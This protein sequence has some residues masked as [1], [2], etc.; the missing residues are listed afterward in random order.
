M[1]I[2]IRLIAVI[3]ITGHVISFL[4]GPTSSPAL[5]HFQLKDWL[6]FAGVGIYIFSCFIFW[7]YSFYNWRMTEFVGNTIRRIWFWVILLGGF[8]YSVGPLIYYITVVEKR[9]GI[10]D[11]TAQ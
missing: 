3:V 6:I 9:K 4:M 7:G 2:I 5:S 10:K 8:L 11:K 1:K